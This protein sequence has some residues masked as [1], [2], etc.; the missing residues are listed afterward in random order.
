MML[1]ST[2]EEPREN[3]TKVKNDVNFKNTLNNPL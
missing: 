1:L 2:P 3:A